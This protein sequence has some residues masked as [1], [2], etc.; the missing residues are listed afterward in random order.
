[1]TGNQ[2]LLT[3]NTCLVC[4]KKHKIEKCDKFIAMDVNQRAQLGKEKRL[5]FSCFESADHQSRDCSRKKRCDLEG[6]NKI[7]PPANP[8]RGTGFRRSATFEQ[9]LD[10]E[11]RSTRLHRSFVCELL[12]LY[13]SAANCTHSSCDRQRGQ[14]VTCPDPFY[15]KIFYK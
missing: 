1:M 3:S 15:L 13:C 6:C 8:R 4:N 14:R 12:P 11:H 7:P 2:S 5:C 10:F 9:R